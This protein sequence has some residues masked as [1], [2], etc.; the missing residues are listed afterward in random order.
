[1]KSSPRF[2]YLKDENN[3]VLVVKKMIETKN[4]LYH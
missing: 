1:V 4:T 2:L 3:F